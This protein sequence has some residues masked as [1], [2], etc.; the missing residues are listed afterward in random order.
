MDYLTHTK[1]TIAI[2]GDIARAKTV[3]QEI[4]MATG[5]SP[6]IVEDLLLVTQEL[7]SNILKHA[8]EGSLTISHCAVTPAYIQLEA[9]DDGPGIHN[10]E[11]AIGDGFSTAGSLGYGLGTVNRLMDTMDIVSPSTRTGGT[12]VCCTKQLNSLHASASLCPFDVGIAAQAYPGLKVNGDAFVSCW[13][14]DSLLVGVIDGLG[15]GQFAH[16]AAER[17]R[18]Y[19]IDHSHLPLD[20]IFLGSSRAS[21]SSRGGVMALCRLQRENGVTTVSYASVGNVEARIVGKAPQI[22]PVVRGILGKGTIRPVIHNPQIHHNDVLVMYSDGISSHWNS[23]V[24][25]LFTLT[26]A[27]DI[28]SALFKELAKNTDDATLVVVKL[29]Y[30]GNY[31]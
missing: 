7:G 21:M 14:N 4:A 19:V 15:H 6:P 10:I 16:V 5:V 30:K 27:N 25:E 1:I 20:R 18:K 9:H 31:Q 11:Q 22:L 12:F 3:I 28:A 26:S 29:K 13:K 2:A 24:F 17:I 23:D 8:K